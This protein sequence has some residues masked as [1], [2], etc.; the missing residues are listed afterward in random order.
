[1]KTKRCICGDYPTITI[2]EETED[3]YEWVAI[4]CDNCC[5][6]VARA[7]DESA[8]ISMWNKKVDEWKR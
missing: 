1:M 2:H 3:E 8:A 7:S 4:S 5:D 6:Y